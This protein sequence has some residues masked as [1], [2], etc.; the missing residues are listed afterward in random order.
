VPC[1]GRILLVDDDKDF[2]E[3]LVAALEGLGCTVTVAVDGMD[4]MERIDDRPRP[5]LVLS[6]LRMPNLDGHDLVHLIR[7]HE[8][9][10]HLPIVSMSGDADAPAPPTVQVHLEKPF[11]LQVLAPTIERS[12]R[13]PD[14][15]H[16]ACCVP[17]GS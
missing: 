10:A 6:D 1:T 12:C 17:D 3:T 11:L 13:D 14:W 15:L 8:G 5:C 2:R 9:L 4:A 16:R 7:C